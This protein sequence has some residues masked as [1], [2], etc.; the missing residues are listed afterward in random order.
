MRHLTASYFPPQPLA[1]RGAR[2]RAHARL[3]ALCD[4]RLLGRTVRL[5]YS[6]HGRRTR[7]AAWVASGNAAA[8]GAT[9]SASW[10]TAWNNVAWNAAEHAARVAAH[11][12]AIHANQSAWTA[13]KN[14]A[15][16]AL[17]VRLTQRLLQSRDDGEGDH[18]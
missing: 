6:R 5:L 3:C 7:A 12:A 2:Y 9:W 11:I 4:R 1:L 15:M 18:P 8:W 14:A 10:N 13:A 16:A 17:N